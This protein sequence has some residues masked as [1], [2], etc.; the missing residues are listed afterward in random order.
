MEYS[1]WLDQKDWDEMMKKSC[2]VLLSQIS[3]KVLEEDLKLYPADADEKTQ[4]AW[5]YEYIVS[6]KL[7]RNLSLS[8]NLHINFLY[9][10]ARKIRM[11]QCII[12]FFLLSF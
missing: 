4:Q 8:S 12:C 2:Q 5:L 7:V 9:H 6:H 10:R 3:L 1:F 11:K